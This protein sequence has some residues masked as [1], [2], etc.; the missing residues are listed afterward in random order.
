MTRG[1][2]QP[3][4]G[5]PPKYKTTECPKCHKKVG[6]TYILRHMAKHNLPGEEGAE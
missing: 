4:S 3:G 6:A 1:G 5:A 2:P